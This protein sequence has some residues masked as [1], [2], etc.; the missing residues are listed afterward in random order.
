MAILPHLCFSSVS[1]VPYAKFN[2]LARPKSELTHDAGLK[3]G[4]CKECGVNRI[5]DLM[6]VCPSCSLRFTHEAAQI[7]QD[8]AGVT[9]III[10]LRRKG[11]Q[12]RLVPLVR[13]AVHYCVRL[14]RLQKRQVCIIDSNPLHELKQFCALRR[15]CYRR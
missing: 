5:I 10:D 2:P 8:L 6:S 7:H 4:T 9:A 3:R 14:T 12:L 1:R 11:Y 15:M 13:M